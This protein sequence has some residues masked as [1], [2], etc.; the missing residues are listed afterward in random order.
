M[1]KRAVVESDVPDP[2]TGLEAFGRALWRQVFRGPAKAWIT[3]TDYPLTR[4]LCMLWDDIHEY[5]KIIA[6][7]PDKGGGRTRLEP[8]VSPSGKV[9]GAKVVAH[10]LTKELRAAE[11]SFEEVAALLG[12][13][14]SS[15]DDLGLYSRKAD[16][17]DELARRRAARI[18]RDSA[19]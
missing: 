18:A 8:I 6:L 2:P 19:T 5:R 9:V 16:A 3:A 15:R 14:M 4:M 17:V 12:L 13:T 10:P 7:P 11:K 1:A